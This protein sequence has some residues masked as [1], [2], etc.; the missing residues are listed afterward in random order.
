VNYAQLAS[1]RKGIEGNTYSQSTRIIGP[2]LVP[3][4]TLNS[5]LRTASPG[6]DVWSTKTF[7]PLDAAGVGQH[8][9]R[10][11][12]CAVIPILAEQ[13]LVRGGIRFKVYVRNQTLIRSC[14]V[15]PIR[16]ERHLFSRMH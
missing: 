1:E 5:R 12:N 3:S 14:A 15:I 9:N 2:S 10:Y 11:R 8:T 6:I 13:P 16:D 7:A 4:V